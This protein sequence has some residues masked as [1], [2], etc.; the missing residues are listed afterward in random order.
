MD[1]GIT[2]IADLPGHLIAMD[3]PY[4]TS[5]YFMPVV[6]LA[7]QGFNLVGKRS[8]NDPVGEDEVGFVFSYDDENTLQWVLSG[9]VSAGT[10]DDYHFDVAF[11]SSATEK[12]VVLARTESVPRQVVVA[13]ADM[14]PE[15]LA[16]IIQVL[17]TAHETEAGQAALEPF[18]TTRFDE[19]PQELEAA[20]N[21]MREMM[22]AIQDLPL[23]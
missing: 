16:V 6:H 17:V 4:S 19:F 21:R 9:L 8:Y 10:I 3:S 1:S 2:S 20:S 23:P 5:G 15:L 12:L 7:D 13:R 14:D 22:E 11:P 18:Q